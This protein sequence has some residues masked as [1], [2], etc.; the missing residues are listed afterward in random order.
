M[1]LLR[2]R[3]IEPATSI[4][5]SPTAEHARRGPFAAKER[6]GATAAELGKIDEKFEREFLPVGV[7]SCFCG[8]V[9]REMS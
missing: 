4:T 8:A 5:P 6:E 3:S 1:C 2:S 7:G 9:R